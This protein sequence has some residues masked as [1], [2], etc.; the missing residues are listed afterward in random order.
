MGIA[1]YV[2]AFFIS[3]RNCEVLQMKNY[4]FDRRCFKDNLFFENTKK[5]KEALPET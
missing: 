5:K 3:N 4:I 1:I 2:Q